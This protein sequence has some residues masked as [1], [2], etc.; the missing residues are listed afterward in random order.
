M[1]Y[2]PVLCVGFLISEAVLCCRAAE[3]AGGSQPTYR[4]DMGTDASPVATGRVRITPDTHYSPDRH[5]GW[6]SRDQTAFDVPRPAVSPAWKQPAGQVIPDDFIVYKE[7]TDVTRDGVSSRMDLQFRVDLP[8]GVYRVALTL[9]RLDKPVCSLQVF[10][11]GEQVATDFDAKHWRSR[12]R[13]DVQYGFPRQLRRTVTVKDGVLRIRIHGDDTNFRE[14]F[15][16]E[17]DRVQPGSY[18]E[19]TYFGGMYRPGR[20]LG[21]EPYGGTKPQRGDLSKWGTPPLNV[22]KVWV[23]EDIGG[24]FTENAVCGLDVYPQVERPLEWR[25]GQLVATVADP[26]LHRGAERFNAERWQESEKEFDSV[27]DQYARALGYLWLAGRPQY[28]EEQRLLPKALEILNQLAPARA[29]DLVFQEDLDSARRMSQAIHRFVCRSA[30]QRSY[31]ELIMVTG[32]VASMQPEDPLYYKSRI[33]AGR[34]MFMVIP[35]RWTYAAGVGRQQFEELERAGFRDNR[36]V[37]WFLHDEWSPQPPDW[38]FHDYSAKKRGAPRW[39]AE[40]FEAYNRELD[41]GEWWIRNRQAPDGSLGGG[42]G[43]DVEILRSLGAFASVCPDASPF[44]LDGIRKVAD[45]VWNCGSVDRDAGYFAEVDDSEHGGEWTAD[46]LPVMIRLDYG[47]PIYVER[48]MKTGKLMRDVWMD[49]TRTGHRIMRSNFLGATG[50]GGE[51]TTNDSRINFRPAAPA[52]GVLGYNNLPPLKKIF[53]EWADAWWSAS[54]ST[55]RGKPRGII[56]QEIGFPSGQIGG[57]RSPTWYLADHPP[58]S[59]NGDWDG[60]TGYH[61]YV[62]DLFVAAYEM[63]GDARYLEPLR[64]QAEFVQRHVPAAVR[65]SVYVKQG[66]LHPTLFEGLEPGSDAWVAAKLATW[67]PQWEALRRRLFGEGPSDELHISRLEEAAAQAADENAGARRRWPHTTSEAMATDRIH[68]PGMKNAVRLMTGFVADGQGPLVS[69]HGLGRDFAALVLRADAA[70]VRVLVHNFDQQAKNASLVPWILKQGDEFELLIGPDENDDARPDRVTESRKFRLESTGQEIPFR[71]DGRSQLVLEIRRLSLRSEQPLLADLA[72]SSEDIQFRPE[73][74]KIDVAVHNIG[75]APARG[76][77]VVLLDEH[78]KEI[79]RQ[80][81]P[82]LAAPLDLNPQ[83]VRVGFPIDFAQAAKRKFT[84]IIDPE[85]RVREITKV[86]NRAT[87]VCPTELA[88]RKIHSN[89]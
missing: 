20:P 6:E 16:R 88:P 41:L 29:K 33:Y 10:L 15:N 62:V 81:I 18:L 54:M 23:W 58:G 36:F 65:D 60:I 63:S 26:A 8:N 32:E 11:N 86:N 67:P 82:H 35:H 14:R 52:R 72:I 59:D 49:Y 66:R 51:G 48:A 87:A 21:L 22:Y 77:T 42:W 31:T 9:G 47:N 5:Y 7:H 64:L 71:I 27:T 83:V 56:P 85:N 2:Y 44:L 43:D 3:I 61:F 12:A 69:Y 30:E 1:R 13:P 45:G 74:Q 39:A 19:G 50:V 17:Y 28:E 4:F 46:T 53:L 55:D 40:I 37:R 24:P 84:A 70:N 79:G 57:E 80:L 68:F 76:L 73:F 25:N 89:P 34:A 75:A 38:V 78:H